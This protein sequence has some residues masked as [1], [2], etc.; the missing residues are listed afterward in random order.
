M[1]LEEEKARQ[2]EAD[3]AKEVWNH[4]GRKVSESVVSFLGASVVGNGWRV[5]K[6][7]VEIWQCGRC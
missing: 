1:A 3:F 2:V 5:E 4:A 6:E 7:P